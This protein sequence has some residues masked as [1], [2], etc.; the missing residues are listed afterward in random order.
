MAGS[1]SGNRLRHIVRRV[2]EV[3]IGF[4]VRKA[5]LVVR[6]YGDWPG[7]ALRRRGL[8]SRARCILHPEFERLAADLR[9]EV[10]RAATEDPTYV[11]DLEARLDEVELRE[12]FPCLGFGSL[13]LPRGAG[14]RTDV[15]TGYEWPARYF[16]FVN[17]LTHGADADVKVPWEL[18]RLQWLVWLA[19]GAVACPDAVRRARCAEAADAAIR[20]FVRANPVGYGPNWTVAMEVAIRA[21]NLVVATAL[22]WPSLPE[23]RRAEIAT[24]LADHLQFLRRF[25]ELSDR[26]GNHFLVGLG[27]V[28]LLERTVVAGPSRRQVPV[29]EIV[30]RLEQQFTPDGMH[31]EHA[32]LY[33]RLCG[34]S[35]LWTCAALQRAGHALPTTLS[36]LA[37]RVWRV[38]GTLELSSDGIPVIGDSDSGQILA[39][40]AAARTTAYLRRLVGLEPG[41]C[42]LLRAFAGAPLPLETSGPVPAGD[43][44]PR[45]RAAGPFR[46]LDAGPFAVLV[47]AGAHG[48]YGRASHDHDDNAAPWVVVADADLLV[49]GGCVGY[50]RSLADRLVDIGSG[51]HN[52]VTVDGR[53]RFLPRAG[54]MSPTVAAAPTALVTA[55]ATAPARL[56]LALAWRDSV[57]GAVRHTRRLAVEDDA[58]P[59]LNVVDEVELDSAAPLTLRWLVGPDWRVTIDGD[60]RV[61]MTHR[62][63]R[64]V[65]A[66]FTVEGGGPAAPP[67]LATE[68]FSP[69]YGERGSLTAVTVRTAA[70]TKVRVTSRFT[71]VAGGA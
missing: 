29:Q 40:G 46:R 15:T 58:S 32:P 5:M 68:R 28:V 67:A 34:E 27:G 56:D 18:A 53:L 23:A 50:T 12:R 63:G 4:L 51:A 9:S 61:A 44:A 13:P 26:L 59:A 60:K 62:D 64:C 3:P 14:W 31:I 48:L 11:T 30:A 20:D 25:P 2:R 33:H 65:R 21:I 35:V 66:L 47:R 43:G 54:A 37:S 16:P 38:L 1:I 71:V 52:L 24:L 69:R 41:G 17:F 19:E 7:Y 36:G 39:P 8:V 57:A 6:P 55:A 45:L 42:A 10:Q 49:D 22:L 70:A